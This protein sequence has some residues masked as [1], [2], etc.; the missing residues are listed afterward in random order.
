MSHPAAL[1]QWQGLPDYM[2]LLYYTFLLQEPQC[3]LHRVKWKY[4]Y[5]HD[6]IADIQCT[7][8]CTHPYVHVLMRDEK[9]GRKKQARSNKEQGKAT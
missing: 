1:C 7:C 8:I 5:I 4:K 9:E 3:S 2:V 6:W